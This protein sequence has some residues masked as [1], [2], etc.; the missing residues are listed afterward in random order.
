MPKGIA[1]ITLWCD[2]VKN[3]YGGFYGA[4]VKTTALW[5]VRADRGPWN[6]TLL[7]PSL[8][9]VT[10]YKIVSEYEL[11]W[12]FTQYTNTQQQYTS[13]KSILVI[14]KSFDTSMIRANVIWII[15]LV[16]IAA[17][18]SVILLFRRDEKSYFLAA[19][20]VAVGYLALVF[21]TECLRANKE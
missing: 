15:Y 9:P 21:D 13:S 11:R 18:C 10:C 20:S 14:I 4:E 2:I 6:V 8:L 3:P 12:E 1:F 19:F 7:F 16:I 5:S 17:L